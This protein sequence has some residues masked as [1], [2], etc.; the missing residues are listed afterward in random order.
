VDHL[1]GC[2]EVDDRAIEPLAEHPLV[3]IEPGTASLVDESSY[4]I[5]RHSSPRSPVDGTSWP[6][7]CAGGHLSSIG[8]EATRIFRRASA[9][10]R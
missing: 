5:R 9:A 8:S 4:G 3:F 10:L 1:T 7:S 6:R 2:G